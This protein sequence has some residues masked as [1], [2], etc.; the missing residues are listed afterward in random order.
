ML[1]TV[2]TA[3]LAF[4]GGTD[5]NKRQPPQR[6]ASGVTQDRLHGMKQPPTCRAFFPDSH[7]YITFPKV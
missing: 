4:A 3:V 5:P 1:V 2:A 7:Y 6:I